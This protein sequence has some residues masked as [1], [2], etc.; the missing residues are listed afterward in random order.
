MK[1][2]HIL[3]GGKIDGLQLTDI[4]ERPLDPYEV[5]VAVK[6]VSLNYRDLMVAEGAYPV[7][8]DTPVIPASDGAGEVT[9]VGSMVTR[10]R[11]GDRVAASFFPQWLGIWR[12]PEAGSSFDAANDSAE[13]ITG[14]IPGS[15]RKRS[16]MKPPER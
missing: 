5:K 9:A 13:S 7:K 14:S 11:P 8:V 12:P 6:A 4:A 2:Y 15:L 10:V 3:H 16:A 1:A